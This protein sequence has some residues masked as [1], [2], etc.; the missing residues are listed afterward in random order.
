MRSILTI[1]IIAVAIILV[2]SIAAGVIVMAYN[3]V[4]DDIAD[5]FDKDKGGY[6]DGGDD[7]DEPSRPSSNNNSLSLLNKLGLPVATPKKNYLSSKSSTVK[8]ISGIQSEAAI[9][10]KVDE[11]LSIAEKNADTR[12]HPASMSK[13]M[14]LIVAC[15]KITDTNAL[16]TVEQRMLDYKSKEGGSGTRY[17]EAGMQISVEDALYLISYRS[18]TVC[19]LMIAEYVSGSEKEFVKLM[20]EKA[21]ALGLKDTHFANTT[22]LYEDVTKG[23]NPDYTYTTCRDMA[24]IMNCAMNNKAVKS[25]ITSTSKSFNVYKNGTRY[26]EGDFSESTRWY[27]HGDRFA[28]NRQITTDL[29]VIAGKTGGEDIPSSCFVTVAEDSSGE[30]YICVVIGRINQSGA[31]VDEKQSTADT[32]HIYKNYIN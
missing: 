24:A 30:M 7:D 28:G 20:N 16:L 23:N 26:T 14:T 2:V 17:L 10:V 12:V 1:A 9:L 25:I 29:K 19:C 8:A 13:L 15:E 5:I 18:D 31:Y 4:F 32:K 6:S 21:A 3:G 27:S 11:N 22:G